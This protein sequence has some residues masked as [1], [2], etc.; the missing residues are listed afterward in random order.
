VIWRHVQEQNPHY[1]QKSRTIYVNKTRKLGTYY[2]HKKYIMGL[3]FC[4]GSRKCFGLSVFF[5]YSF[6]PLLCHYPE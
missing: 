2:V 1:K 3:F 5:Q 6:Y 4:R